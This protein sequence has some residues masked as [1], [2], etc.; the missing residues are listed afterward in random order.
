MS[1]SWRLNAQSPN[2]RQKLA[3]LE[4]EPNRILSSDAGASL[5]TTTASKL[6]STIQARLWAMMQQKLHDP[7]SARRI[8]AKYTG[9]CEP[10]GETPLMTVEQDHSKHEFEPFT[11]PSLKMTWDALGDDI[12]E[13]DEL[14]MLEDFQEMEE[15]ESRATEQNTEDMLLSDIALTDL[16]SD[17]G[18]QVQLAQTA[19][20]KD[21]FLTLLPHHSNDVFSYRNTYR[22][23]VNSDEV[24]FSGA[25]YRPE[26][27]VKSK[28]LI[29]S[30]EEMLEDNHD[31]MLLG[32]DCS[33]T[34]QKFLRS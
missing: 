12:L 5:E 16:L 6:E 3:Q 9:S 11:S 2:L 13:D 19:Y 18:E 20:V 31:E 10:A 34:H 22:H 8:L 14:M 17:D 29:L 30:E 32:S 23:T 25:S 4:N 7:L 28:A 24:C 33:Q 26:G 1:S 27:E 21:K 15:I